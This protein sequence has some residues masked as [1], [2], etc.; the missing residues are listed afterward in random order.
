MAWYPIGRLRKCR[1]ETIDM[2][3]ICEIMGEIGITEDNW[4]DRENDDRR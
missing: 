1:P 3:E 2:H 4:K